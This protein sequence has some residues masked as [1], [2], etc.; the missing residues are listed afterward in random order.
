[1]SDV[2]GFLFSFLLV[3][4]FIFGLVL[5]FDGARDNVLDDCES[6]GA[7]VINDEKWN[8]TK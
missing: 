2:G 8:C 7:F 6:F 4:V 3:A 1:M 5:G